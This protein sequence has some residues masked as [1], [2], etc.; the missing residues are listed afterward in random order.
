MDEIYQFIKAPENSKKVYVVFVIIGIGMIANLIKRV[1][2]E[3]R[4]K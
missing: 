1:M 4:K 3:I 2:D